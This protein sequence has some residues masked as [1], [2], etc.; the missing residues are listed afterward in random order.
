MKRLEQY[1]WDRNGIAF[2]LM[3]LSWVFCLVVGI[4]RLAYRI[5]LLRSTR[6]PLPVI[7]VGN[8][9]VGGSGKTPLVI[10]LARYLQEQGLHPGIISRGYGGNARKWPQQVLPGS[11]PATV[12]DEAVMIA[13]RTGCPV[14][15]GPD[16]VAAGSALAQHSNCDIIISDD[17]LQHYALQ[18]DIEIAVV[19][20]VREL[21]NRF[22]LPAGPLRERPSRLARVDMVVANGIGGRR[23]FS[24]RLRQNQVI[25]LLDPEKTRKITEFVAGEPVH[26]V[27]GIGNP[28]RF[29]SQ[30]EGMGIKLIRHPFP[31]HHPF[32]AG[33]ITPGDGR[34]VLMTEK[35]AI[36]CR[37]FARP[38]QW[39][40]PVT[41]ELDQ[42]F[43]HRLGV[44]VRGVING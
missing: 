29:F 6:L 16:R 35:D 41:A 2:L 17:G 15:V 34:A 3:P 42:A 23:Q 12:G 22:C 37:R 7:V 1:W 18:R 39:Y 24:M 4:R 25:N 40:I 9:T 19:D 26:A 5:G 28:E 30:L 38:E 20:G 14:C 21:G 31:D 44:L 10:W 36:K 33:D 13:R 8:I 27:A 32:S 11:D 43:A